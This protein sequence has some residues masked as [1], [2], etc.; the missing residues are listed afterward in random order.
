[1]ALSI[2][3]C[4]S[5]NFE[6]CQHVFLPIHLSCMLSVVFIRLWT[7]F[8]PL[9]TGKPVRPA[10]AAGRRVLGCTTHYSS[11]WL[12]E[13]GVLEVRFVGNCWNY[14]IVFLCEKLPYLLYQSHLIYTDVHIFIPTSW[15]EN[16]VCNVVFCLKCIY[17]FLN[18][19]LSV[20]T[21]SKRTMHYMPLGCTKIH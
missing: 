5:G 13:Q 4:F 21:V 12:Q 14:W 9:S 11:S 18:L 1:M 7:G 20:H 19:L 6:Y 8:S 15:V 10:C 2:N 16:N 17:V 3:L